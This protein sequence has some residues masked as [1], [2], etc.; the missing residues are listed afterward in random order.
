[1]MKPKHYLRTVWILILVDLLSALLSG[2]GSPYLSIL[3]LP[4]HLGAGVWVGG[5]LNWI[6]RPDAPKWRPAVIGYWILFV[7]SIPG[8]GIF[9]SLQWLIAIVVTMKCTL[10]DSAQADTT[11]QPQRVITRD[12]ET[13]PK[14][15]WPVVVSVFLLF[16]IVLVG[17][18][19]A[20]ADKSEFRGLGLFFLHLLVITPFF[21]VA[22]ALLRIP[23]DQATKP[24]VVFLQY[25]IYGLLALSWLLLF[26]AE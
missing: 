11:Q 3:W 9:A 26:L 6:T 25:L 12:W 13:S 23:S 4:L 2:F 8:A 1:M 22:P 5:I 14:G 20:L 10:V 17:L 19:M 15:K 7:L 21:L 18:V 16:G 24:Y